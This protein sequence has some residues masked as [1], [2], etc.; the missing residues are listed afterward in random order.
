MKSNTRRVSLHTRMQPAVVPNV[1]EKT[2]ANE[3]FVLKLIFAHVNGVALY[4]VICPRYVS[5][6]V[7]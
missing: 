6:I 7:E 3:V 4:T 5:D 2:V 1:F